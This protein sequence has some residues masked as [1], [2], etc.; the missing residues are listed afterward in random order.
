MAGAARTSCT[1]PV[2]DDLAP[3]HHHDPVG[4]VRGDAQVVGDQQH[5]RCPTRGSSSLEVVEDPP[6]HGDVERAGRLVGDDQPGL[7]RRARWRSAPA[8]AS[9]RTARADTAAA[10][11]LGVRQARAWPGSSTASVAALAPVRQAVDRAAPRPTWPPIRFTGLSDDR[12]VLRDQPDL[13]AAHARA[14]RARE[15]SARSQPSRRDAAG[16]DRPAARA[17]ARS[18]RGRWSTCPSRTRR[19]RRRPRRRPTVRTTPRTAGIDRRAGAGSETA[20]PSTRSSG[21]ASA[22]RT[23]RAAHRRRTPRRARGRSRFARE[24]RERATARPGR[25]VSHHAVAR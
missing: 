20:R 10:R 14:A 7:G 1:G 12:R 17:A 18:P 24:H 5:R 2:L 19:R 21:S 11:T 9:R 13:D 8:G 4:A 22:R 16:G 6:L 23:I 3:R 15:P 25:V